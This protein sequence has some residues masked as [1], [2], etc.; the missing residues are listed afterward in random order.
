MTSHL[1]CP[2]LCPSHQ[3][4]VK[5]GVYVPPT[6]V[7]YTHK[8]PRTSTTGICSYF[9][10][11]IEVYLQLK[12]LSCLLEYCL[13]CLGSRTQPLSPSPPR[14]SSPP[15]TPGPPR[16]PSPPPKPDP[17]C[18]PSPPHTPGHLLSHFPQKV[19]SRSSTPAI[20]SSKFATP[21]TTATLTT[22]KKRCSRKSKNFCPMGGF[23]PF[24]KIIFQE[25]FF[26]F[27]M[28]YMKMGVH[29]SH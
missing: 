10:E 13:L 4:L 3:G 21:S 12:I 9:L 25:G 27:P 16:S 28:I 19:S 29:D 5:S 20:P 18:T 6:L 15:P 11:Y 17:P 7:S 14:A 1:L 26:V 23:F 8:M 24:R 2:T 22:A